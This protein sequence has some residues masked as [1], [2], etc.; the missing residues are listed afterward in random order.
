MISLL[1]VGSLLFSFIATPFAQAHSIKQRTFK[2]RSD[3]LRKSSIFLNPAVMEKVVMRMS[4]E[5]GKVVEM[6]EYRRDVRKAAGSESVG[7]G[8]RSGAMAKRMRR[9]MQSITKQLNYVPSTESR[10]LAM[11][12]NYVPADRFSEVSKDFVK[13][14]ELQRAKESIS[15]KRA[16]RK[17]KIIS[18]IS[19][20]TI[21]VVGNWK[22]FTVRFGAEAFPFWAAL[23]RGKLL[24]LFKMVWEKR[25]ELAELGISVEEVFW[26]A[27]ASEE[28]STYATNL[29][30]E[31]SGTFWELIERFEWTAFRLHLLLRFFNKFFPI[32]FEKT[33]V[34]VLNIDQQGVVD[35]INDLFKENLDEKHGV[36][37][38]L[39]IDH[40][41]ALKKVEARVFRG[42]HLIK[43]KNT[44]IVAPMRTKF[45]ENWK[46]YDLMSKNIVHGN[47]WLNEELVDGLVELRETE[48]E[49]TYREM[50]RSIVE[51]ELMIEA[52][53]NVNL[54]EVKS[55]YDS[56]HEYVDN[57]HTVES[58]NA[59]IKAVINVLHFSSDWALSYVKRFPDQRKLF[60]FVETLPSIAKLSG[61]LGGGLAALAV[62]LNTAFNTNVSPSDAF[63]GIASGSEFSIIPLIVTA[64]IGFV[65]Y[66][67][68]HRNQQSGNLLLQAA[69]QGVAPLREEA[70]K[71]SNPL[72][73]TGIVERIFSFY[74]SIV[75]RVEEPGIRFVNNIK[76][77]TENPSKLTKLQ[78]FEAAAKEEGEHALP[79]EVVV[80]TDEQN[81]MSKD[82]VEK[83]LKFHN[84]DF[85]HI[86]ILHH[87]FA[88]GTFDLK[89]L[90][91][92]PENKLTGDGY[93]LR[94]I[95]N[96]YW[97][98]LDELKKNIPMIDGFMEMFDL[99]LQGKKSVD[100]AA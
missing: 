30:N 18:K 19:G 71:V 9:G 2:K 92:K 36:Y 23:H 89:S 88:N 73:E 43:D 97:S 44:Y 14:I 90:V 26:K 6:R 27:L 42:N 49:D 52:I 5:S 55:D 82:D 38:Q 32:Y 10:V 33:E 77:L 98:I 25:E 21:K 64:T 99:N 78:S 86:R 31:W 75:G 35:D 22:R 29:R 61:A 100:Q 24:E 70:L 13:R 81:V 95:N 40:V 4:E 53:D 56:I 72:N 63:N 51:R 59:M 50:I 15:Q 1:V 37:G 3:M 94:V 47:L 69:S 65:W 62:F 58:Q 93:A 16:S 48:G 87:P 34:K 74:Q 79:Y 11:A 28:G 57:A 83:F 68:S 45:I 66:Y 96:R 20:N 8:W 17:R 91:E 12:A 80:V 7:R 46:R 41:I 85:S 76:D 67:F 84:L 60:D 54:R 39:N